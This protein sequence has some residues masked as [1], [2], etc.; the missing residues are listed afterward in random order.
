MSYVSV[1]PNCYYGNSS[2]S[3]PLAA[4]YL[5]SQSYF[6]NASI[7]QCLTSALRISIA[8][9]QLS[10]ESNS[11]APSPSPQLQASE[12]TTPKLLANALELTLTPE[13]YKENN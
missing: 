13:E 2:Q 7:L 1:I 6:N 10:Q 8:N 3:T 12:P 4:H 11:S 5:S 9:Y